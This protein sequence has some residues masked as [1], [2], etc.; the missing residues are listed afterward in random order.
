MKLVNTNEIFEINEEFHVEIIQLKDNQK[1]TVINNLFKDWNKI[2]EL[3][4]ETPAPIFKSTERCANF[5]DYYE[6]R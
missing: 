5:I 1:I 2:R 4:L 6:C 3:F